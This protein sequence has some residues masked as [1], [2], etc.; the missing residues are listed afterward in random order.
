MPLD[1]QRAQ[2]AVSTCTWARVHMCGWACGGMGTGG[3][4]IRKESVEKALDWVPRVRG[5]Q[6]GFVAGWICNF[7]LVTRY[8]GLNSLQLEDQK[9]EIL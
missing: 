4:R 6:P 9:L 1:L 3:L 2:E 7:G 8:C 5:S